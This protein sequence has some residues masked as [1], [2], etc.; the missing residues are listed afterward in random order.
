MNQYDY[1]IKDGINNIEHIVCG[2]AFRSMYDVGKHYLLGI[3]K[4]RRASET[5]TPSV[6]RHGQGEYFNSSLSWKN[7]II[8][9]HFIFQIVLPV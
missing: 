8:L 6:D 5:G 2:T 4:S 7:L 1:I 9:N 3:T